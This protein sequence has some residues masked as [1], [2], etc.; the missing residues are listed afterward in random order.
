M[1][2]LRLLLFATL[3]LLAAQP[4]MAKNFAVGTC[5]PKL[6]NFATI[7]I[8]VS[9]VPPG[10]KIFVCPGTYAEQVVISQPLTL[11]GIASSNQDQAVIAAPAAGLTANVTSTYFGNQVAAQVLVQS[12]DEVDIT[13]ITV[14]GTGGNL[15]CSGDTWVAG[16]FYGS[17]SS[18]EMSRV[19]AKGQINGGCGV[20]IWAESDGTSNQSVTIENSSVHDNDSV[21]ILAGSNGPA[22]TL[23]VE[24]R[25]N[26][27]SVNTGIIGIALNNVAGAVTGNDV[28]NAALYGIG[29]VGNAV[30][31][32]SNAV[33]KAGVGIA[34]EGGG[35]VNKNSISDSDFGVWF[36]SNSGPVES[37]RIISSTLAIEF[38][39]NTPVVA[40]NMIEDAMVGLNNVPLSFSG[41]NSFSNT[42]LISNNGACPA[43]PVIASAAQ[44]A[45]AGG[46]PSS[47]SIWQW[48]TPFSP[49]GSLK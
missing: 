40:H 37:N 9:S 5:N 33:S 45:P 24:I 41:T 47:G 48:R 23:S 35:T 18:G 11:E 20:G 25:R 28:S 8:A 31:L 12:V 3:L 16:I 49:L 38:D 39:C 10:S 43:A 19:T 34:L 46:S 30:S 13:N 6:P 15:S 21:G 7:S 1:L 36:F 42:A 17:G 32:S 2:R 27:V 4:V 29:D 22:P 44:V 14:D 26:V